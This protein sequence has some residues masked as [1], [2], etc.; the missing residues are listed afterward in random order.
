MAQ[1][2]L[3]I[4]ARA[5]T[6]SVLEQALTDGV[7][8]D[9]DRICWCYIIDTGT[10]AYV[11]PN[12]QIHQ[13]VGD[14]KVVVKRL[15]S[16]PPTS[17]GDSEVLYIVDDVV[18]TFDGTQYKPSFYEVKI[19]IDALKTQV[20]GI[21][22]RLEIAEGNIS[23]MGETLRN[24]GTSVD[25]VAAALADKADK[26]DVYTKTQTNDL[27]AEKA[28]LDDVYSRSYIDTALNSKADSNSVYT[29][30]EINTALNDKAD[31]SNTYTKNEVDTM[32]NV[33]TT[34]GSIPMAEYVDISTSTAVQ[35]AND[36][37]D[38]QLQLHFV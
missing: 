37:T 31:K 21:D 28:D 16:L 23:S 19:E 6:L 30:Q 14:N 36:Y 18:Y 10:L 4:F 17:E 13:I 25:A 34:S 35:N 22:T 5:S 32:V 38:Q 20:E 33:E 29:K 9:I 3:P 27:L 11:D 15:S 12:K 26:D 2:I 7:F 8:K 24:L 1:L